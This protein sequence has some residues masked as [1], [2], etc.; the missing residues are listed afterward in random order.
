M[1]TNKTNLILRS[2]DPL[3][4]SGGDIDT[5]FPRVKEGIYDL[6]IRNAESK[7]KKDSGA[8][9]VDG[10]VPYENFRIEC[11]LCLTKDATGVD[12]KPIYKDFPI[13]FRINGMSEKRDGAALQKDMGVLIKSA[14]GLEGA[15][16][17]KANEVWNNPALLNG[18]IVRGKVVIQPEKEGYPEKNDVRLQI[19][20]A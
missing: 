16:T 15:K 18:K 12:G 5:S 2:Y 11:Q 4:I 19:P 3:D 10:K 8:T 14:F 13:T 6:V 7:A 17:I 20:S 9:I 1:T